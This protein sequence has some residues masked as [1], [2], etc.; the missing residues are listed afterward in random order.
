MSTVAWQSGT[1]LGVEQQ[2]VRCVEANRYGLAAMNRDAAI[3][4]NRGGDAIHRDFKDLRLSLEDHRMD[5]AGRS[6]IC[7]LSE[8]KTL[9][10][11]SDQDAA[12][13]GR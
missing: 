5:E 11:H 3:R 10:P 7:G 6:V 2:N 1:R 8:A 13:G 9:R 4:A 12:G